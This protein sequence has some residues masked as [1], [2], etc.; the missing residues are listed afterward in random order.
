MCD[1]CRIR[2]RQYL[3]SFPERAAEVFPELVAT[4]ERAIVNVEPKE[5]EVESK[6]VQD[7]SKQ[8]DQ[9]PGVCLPGFAVSGIQ[10]AKIGVVA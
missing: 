5:S 10:P 8:I 9:G 6:A 7:G 1:V 4:Y 2:W 3:L